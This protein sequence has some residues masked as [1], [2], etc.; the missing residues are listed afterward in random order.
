M[1]AVAP[2]TDSLVPTTPEDPEASE[3]TIPPRN[4]DEERGVWVGWAPRGA[5][6]VAARTGA[7]HSLPAGVTA[8]MWALS[9]R[10]AARAAAGRVRRERV[11]VRYK[12]ENRAHTYIRML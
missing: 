1:P 3:G 2:P 12:D 7:H 6:D 5:G 9:L 8:R 10:R 4:D 11:G